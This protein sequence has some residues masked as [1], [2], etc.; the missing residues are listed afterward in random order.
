MS[1]ST[2]SR[3]STDDASFDDIPRDELVRLLKRVTS[4]RDELLSELCKV[5][6]AK[7]TAAAGGM[8]VPPFNASAAMKRITSTAVREIKKTGHNRNKKPWTQINESL[9]VSTSHSAATELFSGIPPA[10][11]T[12]HLIKWQLDGQQVSDW[13]G[14]Q[15]VHPVKYDGKVWCLKGQRPPKVDAWAYFERLEAKYTKKTGQLQL[16]FRTFMGPPV[17][18]P[19]Y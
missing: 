1:S 15:Y 4:E 8:V 7:T 19:L 13:L 5:K 18:D 10:S 17:L 11:I 12:P 6:K 16:K 14:V 2:L 9:P 3:S